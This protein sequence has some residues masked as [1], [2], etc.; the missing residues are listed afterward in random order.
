MQH[1]LSK[2][3]EK[4]FSKLS[5][6]VKS[7]AIGQLTIFVVDHMDVR[8]NNHSL[9]GKWSNYRSINITGNIRAIYIEVNENTA[10]FV[11]IGSHPKLYG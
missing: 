9:A 3:F 7:K 5:R 2:Q 10:R 8:L 11:D 6:G 1:F 4:S